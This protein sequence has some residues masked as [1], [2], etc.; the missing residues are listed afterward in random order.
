MAI[1][2]AQKMAQ[3][4]DFYNHIVG[5]VLGE[6]DSNSS[7][8]DS[9]IHRAMIRDGRDKSFFDILSLRGQIR[10]VSPHNRASVGRL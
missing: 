7:L 8:D 2:R 3:N 5:N 9:N 1:T 6:Y 10:S 4:Q